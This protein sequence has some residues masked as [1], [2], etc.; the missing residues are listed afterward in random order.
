MSSGS[1]D[2]RCHLRALLLDE[3]NWCPWTGGQVVLPVLAPMK[4]ET[5]HWSYKPEMRGLFRKPRV[6]SGIRR[7]KFTTRLY[8]FWDSGDD[9]ANKLCG[10]KLAW[11]YEDCVWLR[12]GSCSSQHSLAVKCVALGLLGQHRSGIGSTRDVAEINTVLLAGAWH[13][14]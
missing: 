5:C 12:V 10:S 11:L 9:R 7:T 14:G 4:L 6:G 13:R 8:A 1:I 3:G 2:T